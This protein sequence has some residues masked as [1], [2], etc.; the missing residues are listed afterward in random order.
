MGYSKLGCRVIKGSNS[1]ERRAKQIEIIT[2]HI[3]LTKPVEKFKVKKN[4]RN[5]D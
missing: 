5:T 3:V 2:P 4:K 1:S